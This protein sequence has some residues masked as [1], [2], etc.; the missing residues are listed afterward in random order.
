M[1]EAAA[2]F[3][4]SARAAENRVVIGEVSSQVAR[5]GVDYESLIRTASEVELRGLD[6]SRVPRAKR[7][8]VSVALVRMDTLAEPRATDATCVISATLREAKGGKLFAIL[9]GTA[10]AK[11]ATELRSRSSSRRSRGRSTAP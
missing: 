10:R 9:E 11:S 3:A 1:L 6:L 2:L 7:I 5:S 4:V 8:I